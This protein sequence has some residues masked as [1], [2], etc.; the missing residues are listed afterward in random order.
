[1]FAINVGKDG[2]CNSRAV[3][4]I[5]AGH[6]AAGCAAL[7]TGPDGRPAWSYASGKYVQGLQNRRRAE[8]VLCL[9]AQQQPAAAPAALR[10]PD[11]LPDADD[12]SAQGVA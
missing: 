12:S 4:L 2:A 10:G 3:R 1:M 11:E 5:N 6:I 9:D 8:A 7:H